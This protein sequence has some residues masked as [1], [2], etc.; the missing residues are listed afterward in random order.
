MFCTRVSQDF[1][2][3]LSTRYFWMDNNYETDFASRL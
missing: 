3:L 1:Q 2:M